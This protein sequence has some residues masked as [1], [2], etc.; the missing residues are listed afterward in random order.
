MMRKE[1]ERGY[2]EGK[3]KGLLGRIH[4]LAFLYLYSGR[5]EQRVDRKL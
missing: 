5:N 4:D 3:P 1:G 2:L